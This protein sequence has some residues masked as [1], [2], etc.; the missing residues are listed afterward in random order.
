MHQCDAL[1]DSSCRVDVM[2]VHW[3]DPQCTAERLAA[4]L[5]GFK[6]FNRPIWITEFDC[7][8]GDWDANIKL[9]QS[10]LP[11]LLA[12]NLT[13]AVEV[14]RFA[15]YT[16]RQIPPNAYYHGVSLFNDTVPPGTVQLT[17]LGKVYASATA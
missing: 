3:Y 15:W 7:F 1:P 2:A 16:T 6:Q 12:G 11:S 17:E 8:Q 10:V 13:S 14:E 9:A 4:Y 5:N